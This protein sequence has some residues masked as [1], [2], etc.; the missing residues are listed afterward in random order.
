MLSGIEQTASHLNFYAGAP[1][2]GDMFSD[3]SQK[4]R[5]AASLDN[6]EMWTCTPGSMAET[7]KQHELYHRKTD[8]FQLKNVVAK[9]PRVAEELREKL[10]VFMAG[11]R[12]N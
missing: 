10:R 2:G 7:P 8:P 12:T 5:D 1:K 4:M 6:E 11:L 3:A 9:H